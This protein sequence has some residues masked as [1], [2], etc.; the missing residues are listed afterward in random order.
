MVRVR[1]SPHAQAIHI[2]RAL[3]LAANLLLTSFLPAQSGTSVATEAQTLIPKARPATLAEIVHGHVA[4]LQVYYPN[5]D[6]DILYFKFPSLAEQASMLNRVA[7]LIE[8]KGAPRDRIL[9]AEEFTAFIKDEGV[10]PEDFLLGHDYSAPA[11]ARFF[12]TAAEQKMQLNPDEEMLRRILIEEKAIHPAHGG[13]EATMPV[14][15]VISFA[16]RRRPQVSDHAD[17]EYARLRC[18][19]TEHELSHG[20]YFTQPSYKEK[21][22]EF[23]HDH[24]TDVERVLFKRFLGSID[25]DT[26]NED[27]MINETQAF[28]MHTPAAHQF[29]AELL[30]T[31]QAEVRSLRQRFAAAMPPIPLLH[32]MEGLCPRH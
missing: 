28:L 10:A 6:A 5:G 13:Y 18:A 16:E 32:Q 4:R 24:M 22:V 11:L 1:T 27:L 17:P 3:L 30:G 7:A 31:S 23:W 25:Y 12:S 15:A 19:V 26:A 21:V 20:I 29:S 2:V 14:K 8:R 9:S